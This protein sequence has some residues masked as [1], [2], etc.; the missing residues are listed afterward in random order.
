MYVPYR[1]LIKRIISRGLNLQTLDSTFCVT[2]Y[3]CDRR[4][5]GSLYHRSACFLALTNLCIMYFAPPCGGMYKHQ[6][7]PQ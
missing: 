5:H 2:D 4:L 3:N 7:A 6:I 1:V